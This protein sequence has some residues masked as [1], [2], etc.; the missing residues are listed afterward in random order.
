MIIICNYSAPKICRHDFQVY[1]LTPL[2]H[3]CSPLGPNS[4]FFTKVSLVKSAMVGVTSHASPSYYTKRENE[5]LVHYCR[6]GF[7]CE[8]ILIANCEFLYEIQS[9]ES[10]EK[11]HAMNT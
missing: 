11:E 5:E 4:L 10:Q 8:I 2:N 6:S 9:K 3:A 1:N 7:E